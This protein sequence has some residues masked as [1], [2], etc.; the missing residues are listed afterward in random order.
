MSDGSRHAIISEVLNDL[1]IDSAL[2]VEHSASFAQSDPE[3]RRMKNMC[4]HIR[5]LGTELEVPN[6]TTDLAKALCTEYSEQ[7]DNFVGTSLELVATSCLYSAVKV[8]EVP[9]DPTDFIDISGKNVTR[10]GL[11]RWSKDIARK[12]GLDPSM[13]IE[14]EQYVDRYCKELGVSEAVNERAHE[15]IKS[16]E[17]IGLA[18]GKRPSGWAAAAVYNACLDVG[19][20]RTQRELS[21]IANTTELTIRNRYQEQREALHQVK[22]LSAD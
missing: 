14:S 12:V 21:N 10:K 19:E 7:R 2:N 8:T 11:L 22:S 5:R 1:P 18:S 17:K 6:M 4:K 13:F 9:L 15:I 16:T 20:K 3:N